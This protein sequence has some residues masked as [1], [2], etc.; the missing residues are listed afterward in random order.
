MSDFERLS[1][2]DKVMFIQ[3]H[4][5]IKPDELT[6]K[7]IEGADKFDGLPSSRE[8]ILISKPE[9]TDRVWKSLVKSKIGKVIDFENGDSEEEYRKGM[10]VEKNLLEAFIQFITGI[11]QKIFGGLSG[12]KMDGADD[13]RAPGKAR[14]KRDTEDAY[15]RR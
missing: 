7:F 1:H 4:E 14:R 11:L 8:F 15:E 5:N 3:A 6:E 12:D 10:L 2:Q 13:D 9:V